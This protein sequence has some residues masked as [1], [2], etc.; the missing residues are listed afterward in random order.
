MVEKENNMDMGVGIKAL[1]LQWES[2]SIAHTY[3][4]TFHET[5]NLKSSTCL[6]H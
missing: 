2:Y 4:G 3:F 5:G 1:T 6:I